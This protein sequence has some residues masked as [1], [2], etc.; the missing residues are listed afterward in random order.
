M[1]VA[2]RLSYSLSDQLDMLK[3]KDKSLRL[4]EIATCLALQVVPPT[5]DH[6]SLASCNLSR[7]A[8]A[9]L[10]VKLL[11][12][13]KAMEFLVEGDELPLKGVKRPITNSTTRPSGH[14]LKTC[15]V[16]CTFPYPTV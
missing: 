2:V 13:R 3:A 11:P 9:K 7:K 5:C 15:L 4:D 12:L 16:T 6:I 8:E 1:L 14:P 10:A